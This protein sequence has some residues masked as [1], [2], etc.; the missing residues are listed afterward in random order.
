MDEIDVLLADCPGLGRVKLCEC[1]SVHLTLG[2][3][4]VN[5]EPEAFAQAATLIRNAMDQ[6]AQIVASKKVALDP[7][8]SLELR[9]NRVTH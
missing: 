1:N 6:L 8:Q 4:T 9:H 7:L 5:L 2:P 3:V